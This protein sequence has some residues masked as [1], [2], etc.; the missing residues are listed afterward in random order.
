MTKTS[1]LIIF[2]LFDTILDKVWFDYDKVL[3]CLHDR[4]FGTFEKES[5]CGWASEFRRENMLD[6]NIT[7]KEVSFIDQLLYFEE[8]S[9]IRFPDEYSSIE[10]D[11]FNICRSERIGHNVPEILDHLM[12]KG[13]FLAILSNSIFSSGCLSKYLESFG[14]LHYFDKVY[15]SADL[16]FRKP[17]LVV[18]KR[19]CDDFEVEPSDAWFVG[20]NWE[21]DYIGSKNAGLN[22]VYYNRLGDQR[23]GLEVSDLI[24]LKGIVG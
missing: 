1:K 15:S 18:F 16:K 3:D 2:D 13:Y 8:K 6:R 10:W 4:Y 9:G 11:V 17:S 19:V 7:N 14:L 23:D 12:T 22:A 21:K 5:V 20:N 24:E